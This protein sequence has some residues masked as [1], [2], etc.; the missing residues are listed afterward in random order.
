MRLSESGNSGSSV[1]VLEL[2]EY[3]RFEPWKTTS[4]ILNK[5]RR[6]LRERGRWREGVEWSGVERGGRRGGRYRG[7]RETTNSKTSKHHFYRLQAMSTV[8]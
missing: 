2:K 1:P 7:E 4:Y 5:R 8:D 3:F 6:K